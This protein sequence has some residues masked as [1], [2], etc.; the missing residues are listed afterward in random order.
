MWVHF[1]NQVNHILGRVGVCCYGYQLILQA[2]F[3]LAVESYV[4]YAVLARL[5]RSF[6]PAGFCATACGIAIG[7]DQRGFTCV[8]KLKIV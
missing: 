2:H 7:N 4:N 8:G 3:A 1:A 6:W 5:N